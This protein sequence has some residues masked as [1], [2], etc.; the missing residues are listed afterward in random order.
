MNV[1][2]DEQ[3]NLLRHCAETERIM[4][5]RVRGALHQHLLHMGYIEERAV[6]PQNLMIV[7][8]EAGQKVLRSKR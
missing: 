2:S 3:R 1:L 6:K 7:V 5:G 8:T 4:H